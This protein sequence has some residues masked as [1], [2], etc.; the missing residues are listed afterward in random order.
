[1]PRLSSGYLQAES[2][3]QLAP[4]QIAGAADALRVGGGRD[5]LY[6]GASSAGGSLRTGVPKRRL[7]RAT[8]IQSRTERAAERSEL[9]TGQREFGEL[10]VFEEVQAAVFVSPENRVL[11]SSRRDWAGRSLN[12]AS[13]GLSEAEQA[14]VDAAMQQARQTG[15]VVSQFS[16]DRNELA[17]VAP[18]A[19][20]LAPGD[21]R[22]DRRALILLIYDLRFAKSVNAF[23]LQQQFAVAMI[24]VLIAVVGLGI[25]LHF[26]VTR[27]IEHLHGT[28]ARFAAGEPVEKEPT[29]HARNADEIAHLFRHFTGIAATVNRVNRSLRTISNC[30]Q[31]LSTR[32]TSRRSSIRC[33]RSSSRTA[34]IGWPGWGSPTPQSVAPCSRSPRRAVGRGPYR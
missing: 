33:A 28:M 6:R 11:L 7:L 29:P 12:L 31:V 13:L 2:R 23:R 18:A 1:M 4:L 8:D 19:L 21:L 24:G 27:R 25:T 34:A 15:R 20:P 26:F 16:A 14:R 17:I 9:E 10:G 3:S 30:N 32:L 22:L 5:A